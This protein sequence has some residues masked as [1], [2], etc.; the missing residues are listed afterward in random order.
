MIRQ[1]RELIAAV[2]SLSKPSIDPNL[3][4]VVVYLWQDNKENKKRINSLEKLVK[5]LEKQLALGRRLEKVHWN[6]VI[7]LD[8]KVKH[9]IGKVG[10]Q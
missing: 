10:S 6:K 5:K 1:Q 4:K 9:L 8:K 3:Q 7:S 2:E